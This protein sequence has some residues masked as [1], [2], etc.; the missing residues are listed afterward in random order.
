MDVKFLTICIW[1]DGSNDPDFTVEEVGV[2]TTDIL[3]IAGERKVR[4]GRVSVCA[5]AC[6][7]KWRN[8]GKL[9]DSKEGTGGCAR[10]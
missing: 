7:I 8:R 9:F 1:I 10:T 2:S 3:G 5:D 6:Y 4:Q